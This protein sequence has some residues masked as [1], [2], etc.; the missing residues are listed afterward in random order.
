MKKKQPTT[1]D[2]DALVL[3]GGESRRMNFPKA[4]LPLGSGTLIG[5]VLAL[6]QPLFR[7]VLVV[8]RDSEGL[9]G[10]GVEVL[11]DERPERGPLVGLARG[12]AASDAPWCFLVGC[13]MPF[14]RSEVIQ[15]M[16]ERLSGCDILV[17]HL[18]GR[19]QSLHAFYGQGCLPYAREL[20]E[21]GITFPR[22][23]FPH[24]RVRTVAAAD[25]LD[26]DPDLLSFRDLNTMEDYQAARQ[27]I[28]GF[29]QREVTL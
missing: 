5:T 26:I 14:L 12:L 2:L 29:Q 24:C 28:Q 7:R 1:H 4:L 8:A 15:R 17:P 25:F 3:A 6:L 23:L 9:A 10:L 22:A 20:L 27:Q 21:K 13:D 11:T 16:A 19:F 18:E